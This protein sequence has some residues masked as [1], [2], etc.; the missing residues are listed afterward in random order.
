[1]PQAFSVVER[2]R[3]EERLLEAGE[4]LFGRVG[5]R[6]TSIDEI[7][8][9][10]G[11]A[12]GSFYA[13]FPSKEALFLAVIRRIEVR[14]RVRMDREYDALDLPLRERIRWLLL[15][16]F[17]LIEEYPVIRLNFRKEEMLAV[18]RKTGPEAMAENAEADDRFLREYLNRWREEGA[19]EG[20]DP[21][22]AIGMIKAIYFLSMSRDEIGGGYEKVTELLADTLARGLCCRCGGDV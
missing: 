2:E 21:E 10:T 4:E 6:K 5:V 16:Q 11:I 13:F 9:E 14:A 22:E 12:K 1:M 8:R 15:H 3:I 18:I 20:I 19:L 7:A 17:R